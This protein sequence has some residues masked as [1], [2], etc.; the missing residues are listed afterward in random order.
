MKH[1]PLPQFFSNNGH[2]GRGSPGLPAVT[3]GPCGFSHREPARRGRGR[4]WG[5]FTPAW[6]L[7]G[8][9]KRQRT[10]CWS[11]V[12][13]TSTLTGRPGA[14][15]G[16]WARSS[17]RAPPHAQTAS[18]LADISPAGRRA[19]TQTRP[20]TPAGKLSRGGVFPQKAWPRAPIVC[21][22]GTLD[23]WRPCEP[24]ASLSGDPAG[25][26]GAVLTEPLLRA[27]CSSLAWTF[28][29]C[30]LASN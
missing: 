1:C 2:W 14:D 6:S 29:F 17:S 9:P 3:P 27:D 28:G 16:G 23:S 30:G 18:S 19:S 8:A 7:G 24:L 22:Q 11:E 15:G 20:S 10:P 25:Q 21:H 26:A 12:L 5:T 4:A 13:R